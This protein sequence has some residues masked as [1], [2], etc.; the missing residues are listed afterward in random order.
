MNATQA[1]DGGALLGFGAIDGTLNL[2]PQATQGRQSLPL[3]SRIGRDEFH[4][5]RRRA[6][7]RGRA[8]SRHQRPTAAGRAKVAP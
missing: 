7:P 5:H 2:S 3:P 1:E 8:W 4:R 6:D